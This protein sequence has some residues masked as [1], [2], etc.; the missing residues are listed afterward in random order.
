[1]SPRS[2]LPVVASLLVVL[3]ALWTGHSSHDHDERSLADVGMGVVVENHS[4]DP[5][6]LDSLVVL[7]NYRDRFS[8]PI[9]FRKTSP[10]LKDKDFLRGKIKD[11]DKPDYVQGNT[12]AK[13]TTGPFELEA[14]AWRI[15]W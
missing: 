8:N 10:Y 2:H 15:S 14:D 6:S 13:F 11:T 7:H 3:M 12:T 4:P 1:M 5:I 9:G